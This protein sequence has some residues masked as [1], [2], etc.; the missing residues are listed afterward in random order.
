MVASD[1]TPAYG[2]EEDA[3]HWHTRS[4]GVP[5]GAHYPLTKQQCDEYFY[6]S[7]RQEHRGIG[8]V[9]FDDWDRGWVC[10]KFRLHPCRR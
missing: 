7:H 1:L 5:T 10:R 6:L 9:F 3:I 4:Q 8:G 2:F